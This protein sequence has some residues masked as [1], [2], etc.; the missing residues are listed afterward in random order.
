MKTINEKTVL[1][2]MHI[3]MWTG[4]V[5]D[6][7]VTMEVCSTKNSESDSGDWRTHLIPKKQIQKVEAAA[8][9]C[10]AVHNEWTLPWLDG[11]VRVLPA[12][13]FMDYTAAIRKAKEEFDQEVNSFLSKYP[14]LAAT[15]TK[16]L[17]KL[18]EGK[19]LPNVQYIKDRFGVATT[20]L[21]FPNS[22]D[23]RVDLGDAT[24]EIK[25]QVENNIK[26]MGQRATKDLWERMEILVHKIQETLSKPDK[27]FRN[28]LIDNLEDFCKKASKLNFT[29]DEELEN[30]RKEVFDTLAKL[31]P[32]NLREDKEARKDAAKKA[33]DLIEKMK[34]YM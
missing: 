1:V 26:E 24:E 8:A 28:S 13:A 6:A 29:E 2:Q 20:I 4:R 9:R 7:N 18:L 12:T 16:R 19:H 30:I 21:P 34:S 22:K 10:R 25:Q 27:V 5:K 15:A 32:N 23:F 11:G 17:G 3:S 31:K 14:E 33:S